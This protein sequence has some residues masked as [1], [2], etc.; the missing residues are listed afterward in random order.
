MRQ[1]CARV[2]LKE[3]ADEAI[4][5]SVDQSWLSTMGSTR[6]KWRAR[7]DTNGVAVKN[8]NPKV[9]LIGAVDSRGE[10][11]SSCTDT[12]TNSLVFKVYMSHLHA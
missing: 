5:V 7:G 11:Y 1:K 3:M 6:R 4:L 10:I 8:V 9:N 12:N 2:L